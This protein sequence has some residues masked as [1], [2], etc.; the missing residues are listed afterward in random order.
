MVELHYQLTK[1]VNGSGIEVQN[2]SPEN[3]I[4]ISWE[5]IS[6]VNNIQMNVLRVFNMIT[7]RCDN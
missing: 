3:E 6:R 4:N 1:T 7:Y 5:I 2:N